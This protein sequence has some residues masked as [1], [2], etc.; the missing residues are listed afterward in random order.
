MRDELTIAKRLLEVI[1]PSMARIR[2][3]MRSCI[4][5]ELSVPDFRILAS[6]VRGKNLVS[7]IARHH[8]VSQP[9][10]SRSV[11]GLVKSGLIE[12]SRESADRRQAPLKLTSKGTTLFR[13]ITIAAEH[14]LSKKVSLLDYKSR[15]AL[16]DGMIQLEKLFSLE[17]KT[18]SEAIKKG[19]I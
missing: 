17:H 19:K 5:R 4:P 10:M 18:A 2:L 7:D 15:R 1:P 16:L 12:R 13:K 3:E 14:N 6:I 8:G 11:D 9:S